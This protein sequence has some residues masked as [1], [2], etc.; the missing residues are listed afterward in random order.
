[1]TNITFKTLTE[2]RNKEDEQLTSKME[3]GKYVKDAIAEMERERFELTEE[4]K[5]AVESKIR[6]KLKSGKK[7]TAKEMEYL[8]MYNPELY[9]AALKMEMKRKMLRNQLR[10]AKSK[11]EVQQAIQTAAAGEEKDPYQ[12]YVLAMVQKEAEDFMRSAA[13]ARLPQSVEEARKKKSKESGVEKYFTEK[14]KK[15]QAE[16]ENISYT[17]QYSVLVHLKAQCQ[18]IGTLIEDMSFMYGN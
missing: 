15:E 5:K 13:Y 1:M 9:R 10:H 14:E 3:A 16:D 4:E 11:E 12:E 8:K 2:D 17:V 7:L 6:W 18:T